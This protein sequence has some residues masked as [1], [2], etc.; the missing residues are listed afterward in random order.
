M[1]EVPGDQYASL[2]SNFTP[3]ASWTSGH[4]LD[5][6]FLTNPLDC[7]REG[8]AGSEESHADQSHP[9]QYLTFPASQ[10]P[11]APFGITSQRSSPPSQIIHRLLDSLRSWHCSGGIYARSFIHAFMPSFIHSFI[12]ALRHLVVNSLAVVLLCDLSESWAV[13]SIVPMS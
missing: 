8:R 7:R 12:R 9:V 10:V 1:F 2:S 13:A 4:M 3:R 5:S 11:I 6:P